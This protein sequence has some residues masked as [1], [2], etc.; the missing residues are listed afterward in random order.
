MRA[1]VGQVFWKLPFMLLAALGVVFGGQLFEIEVRPLTAW[2]HL[3]GFLIFF[4]CWMM[5]DD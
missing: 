4:G 2:E 3:G 1:S 5:Y